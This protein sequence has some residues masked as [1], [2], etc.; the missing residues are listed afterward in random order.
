MKP[1]DMEIGHLLARSTVYKALC[2]AFS[3]PKAEVREFLVWSLTR[4]LRE[5]AQLLPQGYTLA[6]SLKTLA[7]VTNVPDDLEGEYNRLFRVQVVCQPY[8][9]EHDPLASVRKGQVLADILGFYQAFGLTASEGQK[10]FPDFIATELEFM[11]LLLLKEACAQKSGLSDEAEICRDAAKKFLTD[12]LARWVSSFSQRL[13]AEARLPLYSALGS[14]LSS[15]LQDE[16]ACLG[17]EPSIWEAN[18][19]QPQQGDGLPWG[20]PSGGE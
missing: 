17:L 4:K 16:V 15:F 13:E 3:P 6:V 1:T 19:H 7:G 20:P 12:H 14:I 2:V 10:E 9:T 5:A 11:S 18:D 8:E